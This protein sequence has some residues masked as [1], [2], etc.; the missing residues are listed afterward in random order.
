MQETDFFLDSA[1]EL[2]NS[3]DYDLMTSI[4]CNS[5][6]YIRSHHQLAGNELFNSTHYTCLCALFN[7]RTICCLSGY[8]CLLNAI[9]IISIYTSLPHSFYFHLETDNNRPD[10]RLARLNDSF[11]QSCAA[12]KIESMNSIT[13]LNSSYAPVFVDDYDFDPL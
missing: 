11:I 1:D 8:S 6:G 13:Y 12:V 7:I 4:S 3:L 5:C 10:V 9:P 2:L